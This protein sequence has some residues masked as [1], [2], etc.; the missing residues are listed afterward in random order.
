MSDEIMTLKLCC[1]V[2]L[3]LF[4]VCLTPHIMQG[5]LEV[6]LDVW[7]CCFWGLTIDVK[8]GRGIWLLAKGNPKARTVGRQLEGKCLDSLGRWEDLRVVK[9][10]AW[11]LLSLRTYRE[12]IASAVPM[13][14]KV[15]APTW[16][17]Q[18]LGQ[19][20]NIILVWLILAEWRNK[21]SKC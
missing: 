18:C 4:E 7:L 17:T 21:G 5:G 1:S 11:T 15:C 8:C 9:Q 19:A 6:A 14:G 2:K 3:S 20:W 12:H 16:W 13:R 10:F